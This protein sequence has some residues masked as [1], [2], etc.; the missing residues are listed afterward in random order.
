MYEKISD[1]SRQALDTYKEQKVRDDFADSGS[2]YLI[3][4]LFTNTSL[5][6]L[7]FEDGESGQKEVTKQHIL[8][9]LLRLRQVCSH[10]AL[11]LPKEKKEIKGRKTGDDKDLILKEQE[12]NGDDGEIQD[13]F[14]KLGFSR[15]N[16]VFERTNVSSKMSYIIGELLEIV[17]KGQK[18]VVVSQ[19]TSML[20][21]FKLQLNK[22]GI[23]THII[24]GSVR[25]KERTKIVEDF[26]K[27]PYG[28]PVNLLIF[29]SG[30]K[31]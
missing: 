14:T 8:E 30:F 17:K 26:N 9:L 16:P 1:F 19:W 2:E 28:P 10:P 13:W 5:S 22:L 11:L 18:A 23:K 24:E 4:L 20:E 25:M 12:L 3:L 21:L 27:N 15:S 31:N 6:H 7:K 29:H